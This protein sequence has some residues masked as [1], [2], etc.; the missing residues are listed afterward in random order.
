VRSVKVPV[1]A[2]IEHAYGATPDAVADVVLRVIATGAVGINLE[3][4]VPG[5]SDLVALPLQTDKIA[6][7]VKAA[8]TAGVKVVINARTDGF[9]RAMGSPAS[10]LPS[11]IERGR[12]FLAA[13]ADCVF[14]PG[15]RDPDTIAALVDGIGGPINILAVA[16]TPSV[17]ELQRLGVRRVSLGSGPMRASLALVRDIAR[18]LKQ[19]GTYAAFTDHALAYD[20]VNELMG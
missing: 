5:A 19:S 2:D 11:A 8:E 1:S 14:V 20:D 12:A 9:L 17:A 16:G 13:G 7:I 3:D 18:Q 4:C 15:V 6:S 10:R